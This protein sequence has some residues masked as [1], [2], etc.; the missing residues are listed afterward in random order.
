MVDVSGTTFDTTKQVG[1]MD[2]GHTG[3]LKGLE[4]NSRLALIQL[5]QA[6]E[7]SRIYSEDRACNEV[8]GA[9]R[10]LMVP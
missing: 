8:F 6:R 4:N 3:G 1:R 5:K 9:Q 10:K 2:R 7:V